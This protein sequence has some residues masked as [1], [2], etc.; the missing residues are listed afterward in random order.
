MQLEQEVDDE[1]TEAELAKIAP[2]PEFVVRLDEPIT[3]NASRAAGGQQSV[4]V[5]RFRAPRIGER[6][7]A[8]AQLKAGNAQSETRFSITLLALNTGL[9]EDVIR[10]LPEDVFMAGLAYIGRFFTHGRRIGVR[11]SRS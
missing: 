1:A 3:S 7:R 5:V 11:L 2:P 9:H 10:Q 4:D 8:E 6:E